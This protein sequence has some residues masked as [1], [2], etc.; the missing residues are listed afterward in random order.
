M[1]TTTRE[2][3]AA[4]AAPRP[5]S[6]GRFGSDTMAD[7]IRALD[8]RY[9][10]LN[11]GASYRGLHDSLVNHLGDENPKMLVC[12]H[13]EAAVALAHGYGKVAERPMGAIVHSNVG[14]MHASMAIFDAWCDRVPVVVFGATGPVAADQRRPWIDWIH[15]TTDQAQLVR[16]F[17]KWDNQPGSVT[18]CVEAVLRA[19]MIAKTPPYGPVYVVFDALLQE[20][21][22]D[23]IPIPDPARYAPP[24]HGPNPKQIAMLAKLLSE[25]KSPVILAG[26]VSRSREAWKDRIALAER[27]GA[28]VLT[29]GKV[30]AA[31]PSHHPLHPCPPTLFL[32]DE[33]R[34]VV[35]AADVIL[36]L[37]WVDLGG[38]LKAAF[39]SNV[40]A[41]VANASLDFELHRGWNMEYQALPV[42]DIALASDPDSVVTA[43]LEA[44]GPAKSAKPLPPP[45]AAAPAPPGGGPFGIRDV[46]AAVF[47]AIGNR[48]TTF[49]RLP[50]G[51]SWE[52]TRINDPL[53]YL[54]GD[55][56][57]GVGSGPGIS[58]GAA[59]AL[60]DYE[61]GRLPVAV[62]GD[63]DFMMGG[64]AIWTA[65]HAKIP[66]LVVVSNNRSYFNDELHQQRVAEMRDRPVERRWIGQRIDG[67]AIDI[68]TYA[69]SLGATGFGPVENRAAMDKALKEAL[70]VV[71]AGGV[72]VIDALV[73]PAYDAKT[74]AAMVTTTSSP[75]GERG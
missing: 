20:Q 71:E 4:P 12:L 6:A 31:F 19:G 52:D 58:V 33:A 27:L 42:V 55:G 1:T 16:N 9:V 56:G 22:F 14:L 49:I 2:P 18:A 29:D 57:G 69:K 25:A 70:A 38:A 65:V 11:P 32:Q 53:D 40:K 39:G 8:L 59:L 30:A 51:W 61:K 37:D 23:A 48:P 35:A 73:L 34:D 66:L 44:L 43:L 45:R 28:K 10:A 3:A 75:G 60:R 41:K 5:A 36:S 67:P 74:A 15:T 21:K 26:R 13:E 72:A 7:A 50:I 68:A 63:G 46:A 24:V 64:T 62:V 47:G 54:G 17:T